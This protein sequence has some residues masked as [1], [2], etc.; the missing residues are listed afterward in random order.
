MP[1]ERA[2]ILRFSTRRKVGGDVPFYM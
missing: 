1:Y 2:I